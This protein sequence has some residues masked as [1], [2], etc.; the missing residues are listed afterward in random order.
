MAHLLIIEDEEGIRSNL[1]RFFKME[2]FEVSTATNG[3]EGIDLARSLLPDLILCD[4]LMPEVNGYEV[5]ETLQSDPSTSH[6]PC[7]VLSA[8]AAG[9]D[10]EAGLQ[11]GAACYLTKPFNLA[12]V[13]AT[14]RKFL[15]AP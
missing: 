3:R 4:I 10:L 7:V 8:S 6:I 2:G 1:S 12:D 11:R 9:S 15:P 14:V 13:L 5:L